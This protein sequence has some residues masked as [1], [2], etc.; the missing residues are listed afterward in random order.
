MPSS[1]P[2]CLALLTCMG[3]WPPQLSALSAADSDATSIGVPGS[4]LRP[5]I[6]DQTITHGIFTQS[7]D[8]Q[9]DKFILPLQM[10]VHALPLSSSVMRRS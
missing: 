5:A 8:S 7:E 6:T 2:S 1:L 4:T 10:S 3:S 9:M